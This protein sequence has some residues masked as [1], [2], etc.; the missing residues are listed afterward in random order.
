MI[1]A[2][3]KAIERSKKNAAHVR[4]MVEDHQGVTL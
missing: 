4:K 1:A 3:I 2:G